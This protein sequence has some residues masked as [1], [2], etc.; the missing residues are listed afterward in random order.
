MNADSRYEVST[1]AIGDRLPTHDPTDIFPHLFHYLSTVLRFNSPIKKDKIT[2]K[3]FPLKKTNIF[4]D[5]T[6][7]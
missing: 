7:S 6:S 1:E 2:W 5:I 3:Y 4:T